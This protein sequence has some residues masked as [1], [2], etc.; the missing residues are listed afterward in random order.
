MKYLIVL[1]LL[2]AACGKDGKDGLNGSN[3][4]QGAA[5]INGVNGTNGADGQDGE[6]APVNPY[7]IATIVDPC[8]DANGVIDEILLRLNNNQIIAS[9]TSSGNNTRFALV[10]PG[11][12]T[13][14]DGSNC[15]F[16]VHSDGNVTW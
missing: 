2:L 13:T 5:G 14:T 3:G 10:P 4:A 9:F 8:G 7:D 1:C 16:T 12:Y 11:T 15:L 6:D